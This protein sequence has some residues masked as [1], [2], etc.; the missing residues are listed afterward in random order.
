VEEENYDTIQNGVQQIVETA[1]NGFL[2]A[3]YLDGAIIVKTDSMGKVQWTKTYDDISFR[4]M[5]K[6]KEGDF[7][8]AGYQ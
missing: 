2:F 8:F 3:G 5:L 1:D 7:V 4:S 6:T